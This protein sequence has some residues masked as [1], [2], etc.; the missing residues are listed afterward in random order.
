VSDIEDVALGAMQDFV[1]ASKGY[2]GSQPVHTPVAGSHAAHRPISEHAVHVE[3]APVP[4]LYVPAG[5]CT[6]TGYADPGGQ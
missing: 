3:I 6:P 5:H 2:P 4:V 1:T